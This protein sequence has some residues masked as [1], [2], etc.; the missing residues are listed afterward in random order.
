MYCAT[1]QFPE[2]NFLGHNIKPHGICGLS[3][4]YHMRFYPRLVHGA[5]E[6]RFIPCSFTFCTS[7]F[8]QPWSPGLPT[9]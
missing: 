2:L 6:I 5:Y 3:Q 1:N 7:I 8:D 4:H 9:Q